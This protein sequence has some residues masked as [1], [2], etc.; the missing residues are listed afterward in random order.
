LAK[1]HKL[2]GAT[3]T[4]PGFVPLLDVWLPVPD[5]AGPEEQLAWGRAVVE[6][7]LRHKIRHIILCG[8]WE[9]KLSWPGLDPRTKI[10]HDAKTIS[11]SPEDGYRV[12]VTHLQQTVSTFRAAGA[13]VWFI[14]QVPIQ[15]INLTQIRKPGRS[16]DES[17]RPGISRDEY[18]DQQ[19]YVHHGLRQLA[20][21]ALKVLGPGKHWFD[22]TGHSLAIYQGHRLYFDRDHLTPFGATVL[23]EPLL[24]PVFEQMATEWKERR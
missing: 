22:G 3:A 11:P 21:P 9:S 16:L 23:I 19:R 5:I 15:D 12:F 18:F 1:Q 20:Q 7:S 17:D 24:E 10:M 2:Q 6:W 4:R 8:R 14:N 13:T